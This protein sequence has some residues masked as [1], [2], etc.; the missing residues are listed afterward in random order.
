MG[1][2]GYFWVFWVL[3]RID[4][5]S[6]LYQY[7]S[8]GLRGRNSFVCHFP[9]H[10]TVA[11]LGLFLLNANNAKIVIMTYLNDYFDVIIEYHSFKI[12]DFSPR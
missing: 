10:A 11:L 6:T 1:I 7:I 12:C 5:V 3:Y 9:M 4:I 2:S 8:R